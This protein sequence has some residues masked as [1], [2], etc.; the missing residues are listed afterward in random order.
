[1]QMPTSRGMQGAIAASPI[2]RQ[3]S[4][5]P[6]SSLHRATTNA[7]TTSDR[8]LNPPGAGAVGVN[9]KP[10]R[11]RPG[12]ETERRSARASSGRGRDGPQAYPDSN[13]GTGREPPHALSTAAACAK[14][15]QANAT[16]AA[17]FA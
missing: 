4:S 5:M 16:P 15:Q 7:L 2:E 10:D 6:S 9:W 3:P 8:L 13:R 1:M 12:E 14:Q 17:E 11:A